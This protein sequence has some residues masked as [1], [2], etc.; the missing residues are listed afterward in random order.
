MADEK[1]PTNLTVEECRE[2]AVGMFEDSAALPPGPKKDEL[3]KLA[4]GYR[5]LAQLK[6]WL[7]GKLN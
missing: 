4:R 7:S 2:L 3:L 5:N 6:E 1:E